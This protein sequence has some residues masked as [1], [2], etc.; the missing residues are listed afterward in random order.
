MDLSRI[1]AGAPGF[2][3]NGTR[4]TPASLL[5]PVP[6]FALWPHLIKV[7]TVLAA[8]LGGLLL[9]AFLW[10][11]WGISRPGGASP[12]IQVLAT[13]YLAPKKALLLV[14]VGE[15][16]FLLASAGDQLT[17]ITGLASQEEKVPSKPQGLPSV[18]SVQ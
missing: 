5:G 16:R 3:Q 17:L 10:K 12:L 2:I 13:H 4:V 11:R 9:V 1:C 14:G 15:E 7:V 18:G 8:L 6:E